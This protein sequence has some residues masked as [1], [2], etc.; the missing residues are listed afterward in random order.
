[1]VPTAGL[2][3]QVT[4]APDGK[5]MTENC[6]VPDGATVAVAGLTLVTGEA[7]SVK[8]A[9]PNTAYATGFVDTSLNAVIVIV[10]S[11]GTV[12]GAV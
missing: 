4:L 7:V 12:A 8:L 2:A 5:F 10:C 6:S 11:D 3:D 9:V 1:M